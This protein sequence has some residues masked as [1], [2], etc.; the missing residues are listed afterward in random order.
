MLLQYDRRAQPLSGRADQVSYCNWWVQALPAR[1]LGG[2][3][4][5]EE[6]CD[7]RRDVRE[8]DDREAQARDQ[9][10]DEQ[11]DGAGPGKGG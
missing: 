2:R 5:T 11:Q 4:D 8:V 9:G 7:G 3:R 1:G 10:R 6:A